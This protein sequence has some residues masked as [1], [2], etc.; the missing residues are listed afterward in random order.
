MIPLSRWPAVSLAV[1]ILAVVTVAAFA[2]CRPTPTPIPPKEQ[3]SIDSLN[4]T[5]P[6]YRARRDTLVRVESVYVAAS[7]K[8]RAGA[9]NAARAADSLRDVAIA[10]QRTAEAQGDTSSRWYEVAK[11]RGIENDSLRSANGGLLAALE[12][13][14]RARTAADARSVLDS[15]RLAAVQNLNDRMAA[16][17]RRADPPCRVAFAFRCPSR[18]AVA[19]TS[20]ALGVLGVVAYQRGKP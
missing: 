9:I 14:I 2:W 3:T 17:L 6:F 16:D 8:N 5:S 19:V 7:L 12:H 20:L 11:V 1:G 15:S 10:W 13:Q 18:K 4:V